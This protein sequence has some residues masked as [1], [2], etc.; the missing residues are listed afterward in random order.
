MQEEITTPAL[1]AV[2]ARVCSRCSGR[3]GKTTHRSHTYVEYRTW[4]QVDRFWECMA[5]GHL[6]PAHEVRD[7][8][9][10]VD[11]ETELLHAQWRVD[12]EGFD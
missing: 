7:A 9:R 12:N 11:P 6:V 5:C 4:R 10:K 8:E 2:R 3:N 1:G